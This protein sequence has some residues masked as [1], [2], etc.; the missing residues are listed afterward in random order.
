MSLIQW[1]PW[2]YYFFTFFDILAVSFILYQAIF[3]IFTAKSAN[4]LKGVLW[5]AGVFFIA[6]LLKM[7][8][9]LWI[10]ELVL[11]ILP[12]AVLILFHPEIRRMLSNLGTPKIFLKYSDSY[13]ESVYESLSILLDS[14][15][16]L[17]EKRIGALILLQQEM[18]LKGIKEKAVVLDANLSKM[19]LFSI[20]I[21]S[22]P[23]HD[24]A[25]IIKGDRVLVARAFFPITEEKVAPHL[26]SR[27]RAALGISENSDAIALIVSEE[28]GYLSLAHH[29]KMF[30]N[31]GAENI[32]KKIFEI[33][34]YKQ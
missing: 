1:P 32:Q 30:Y 29:G 31:M 12:L 8:T 5:I 18:T 27:H 22:S 9:L 24:G 16:E 25:V 15:K 6:N 2:L 20:F 19:L 33:L 26:G 23:L 14:M 7:K 21:P 4:L 17:S 3:H 10:F 13:K 28:T 34:G 11:T